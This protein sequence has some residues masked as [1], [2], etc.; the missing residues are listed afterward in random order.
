MSPGGFDSVAAGP[1]GVTDGF[2]VPAV[3][4]DVVLGELP[5]EVLGVVAELTAGLGPADPPPLQPAAANATTVRDPA[6][7]CQCFMDTLL[8]ANIRCSRR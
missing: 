3:G 5:L 4:V 7:G 6:N 8:V 2:S 1:G